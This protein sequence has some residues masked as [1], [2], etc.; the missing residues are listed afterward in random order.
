MRKFVMDG[1]EDLP[2]NNQGFPATGSKDYALPEGG[3]GARFAHVS[4]C[5]I[6]EMSQAWQQRKT[7][8]GG[9]RSQGQ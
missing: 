2:E 1:E 9:S 7:V 3:D 5:R 6:L 4:I 8:Q